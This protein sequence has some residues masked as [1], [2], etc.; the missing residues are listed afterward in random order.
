MSPPTVEL[1]KKNFLGDWTSDFMVQLLVSFNIQ[2]KD[3]KTMESASDEERTLYRESNGTYQ[4]IYF[5]Y[6]VDYISI[7]VSALKSNVMPNKISRYPIYI[8]YA[9]EDSLNRLKCNYPSIDSIARW[10]KKIF[11]ANEKYIG[12]STSANMLVSKYSSELSETIRNNNEEINAF[13][14]TF[15]TSGFI[16]EKGLLSI[17]GFDAPLSEMKNNNLIIEFLL[18]NNILIDKTTRMMIPLAMEQAGKINNI[19]PA[20]LGA[21]ISFAKTMTAAS[22]AKSVRLNQAQ[23][24]ASHF[25]DYPLSSKKNAINNLFFFFF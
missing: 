14:K 8:D 16:A 19:T 6:F 17:K 2:I 18:E 13:L 20:K 25:S 10:L 24:V 3:L 7:I 21:V 5:L 9:F 15:S 22:R 4:D 23:V 12:Q 11:E 1:R